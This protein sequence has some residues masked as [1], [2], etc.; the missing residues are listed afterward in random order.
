[1]P[2]AGMAV[3]RGARD[4]PDGRSISRAE[5]RRDPRRERVRG[6]GMGSGKGEARVVGSAGAMSEPEGAQKQA[7]LPWEGL[8]PR[9][10]QKGPPGEKYKEKQE[11][12]TK[13]KLK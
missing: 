3:G 10:S 9:R 6:N 1:M 4:G 11:E 8:V 2:R 12:K 7:G 13:K 5:K